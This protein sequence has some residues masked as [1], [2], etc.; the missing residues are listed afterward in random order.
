MFKR[1][2]V[3]FLCLVL[4][5]AVGCSKNEP[6]LSVDDGDLIKEEAPV[7]EELHINNLTGL[8]ELTADLKDNRPIAVMVNNISV[9]QSVQTGLYDADIVYETEVEGGITRL[10]AVYKN[11]A[12][13]KKIG[14][15]RSAR[16]DYIDLA[17]G[18][19]AVYVH[20]GQDDYH[21]T[22]H[23]NAVDHFTVGANAGGGRE[24][25]GLSSEHTL[26]AYGDKLYNA[27]KNKGI[28]LK[29]TNSFN[30]VNF[31]SEEESIKLENTAT[32][33]KVPFSASYV[34]NFKYNT[35]SGKYIRYFGNTERKDYVTGEAL[36]FKNIFVLKTHI[37]SFPGC[38]DGKGHVDVGLESGEGYYVVNG[39][40]TPI[41][42]SKGAA[43]NGFK[44]TNADGSELKVNAGNSWV[45][46]VKSSAGIVLS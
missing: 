30:W 20:H 45:C 31:A 32:S 42:W 9:A 21:A 6:A 14:T 12:E 13:T 37:G 28:N 8:K 25:N 10:L 11:I 43:S 36:E 35:E 27:I 22:P 17:A 2:S 15:V 24:S 16:Y 38:T 4:C 18:H 33:V 46:L 41:K 34:T 7:V 39:T 44:F 23:F 40:Y 26:Y 3:L 5:F 1:I 19:N 29:E